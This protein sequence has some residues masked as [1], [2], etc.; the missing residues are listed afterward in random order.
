M[1]AYAVFDGGGVK[2]A[3]LAGALTAAEQEKI[4]FQGYGGTSAGSIVALLA[5]IGY[6]GKE[7]LNRLKTVHPALSWVEI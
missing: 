2:G 3:A 6:T 4:E 1:K 7:I 5:S